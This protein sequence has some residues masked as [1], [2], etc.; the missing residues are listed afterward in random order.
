MPYDIPSV[1]HGSE[2]TYKRLYYSNPDHAL[3]V[4][5]TLQA[6]YGE[7]DAGTVLA[8]NISA[9]GNKGKLV[10]YNATTFSA[11]IASSGRAFLLESPAAA[12]KVVTVTL[13]DSYKF[14]VGDDLIINDNTVAAEN[15]G[16]I[17]AIDTTTYINKAT[18]TGT[19][20]ISG[21]FTVAHVAY[22]AV[23]AGDSSNNFSDA[24]GILEA[25]VDTGNGS[26]ARDALGVVILSNAMLYEGLLI[27][28]DAA[29]KTDLS[30]AS[31]GQYLIMK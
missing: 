13:E 4:P 7:L 16:A 9:A 10:P 28:S 24:V 21:A 19:T 6:G 12:Q 20:N 17:T 15:L 14:A 26:D 29:A 25:A 31:K 22:V 3:K 30:A 18:I 2:Q 27:Y 11:S 5:V 1:I 23:E 8:E